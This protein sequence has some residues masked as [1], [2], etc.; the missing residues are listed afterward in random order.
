MITADLLSGQRLA[1]ELFPLLVDSEARNRMAAISRRVGRP[2]AAM[3][4]AALVLDY[5]EKQEQ[6]R[7]SSNHVFSVD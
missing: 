7:S 1:E 6:S 4:V 3:D 5:A 2:H